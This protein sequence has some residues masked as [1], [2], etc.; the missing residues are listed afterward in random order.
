[1][2]KKIVFG[3]T[4]LVSIAALLSGCSNA[5]TPTE[6]KKGSVWEVKQ[7]MSSSNDLKELPVTKKVYGEEIMVKKAFLCFHSNGFVY[8]K[9][10]GE[11][12]SDGKSEVINGEG[13]YTIST[14]GKTIVIGKDKKMFSYTLESGELT[15]RRDGRIIGVY[16]SSSEPEFT[17]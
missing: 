16:K 2:R 8:Q 12:L 9:F 3:L 5:F 10:I 11:G 14:V 13:R 7:M 15:I 6:I 1:M 4:L 17:N